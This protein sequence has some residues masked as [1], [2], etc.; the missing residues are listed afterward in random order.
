M[1]GQCKISMEHRLYPNATSNVRSMKCSSAA[2]NSTRRYWAWSGSEEMMN[3][4]NKKL[5]DRVVG[6]TPERS[7]SSVPLLL[8]NS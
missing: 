7:K 1:G 2:A 3:R 4:R 8:L 6:G 5:E